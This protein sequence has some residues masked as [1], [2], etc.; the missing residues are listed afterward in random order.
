MSNQDLK[1]KYVFKIIII[2][3]ASV[4][5]TSLFRRFVNN[6]FQEKIEATIGVDCS[7]KTIEIDN[8]TVSLTLWDTAGTERYRSLAKNFYRNAHCAFIVFD[9]TSKESFENLSS[10]I[11]N[12]YTLC[13]KEFEKNVIIIGN[14]NDDIDNRAVSESEIDAFM[15]LNKFI[16][17]E[18][19]ARTGDNVEESFKYMAKKLVEEQKLKEKEEGKKAANGDDNLNL[20]NSE[21]ININNKKCCF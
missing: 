20:K 3:N 2:G 16:Y 4:G 15:K 14:K 12:F 11:E 19:S 18:T 17:F 7:N 9:L 8:E 6:E 1:Y 10:W 21:N 13:N 5:K